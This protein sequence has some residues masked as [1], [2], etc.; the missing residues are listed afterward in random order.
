MF[1]D[2]GFAGTV[3]LGGVSQTTLINCYSMIAGALTPTFDM[4]GD[5]SAF[6]V[7]G[8]MGGI[9]VTNKTGMDGVS[10][11]LTS[12]QVIIDS[13]VVSGDIYVR[14][15]GRLTDNSTGTTYVDAEG[16][17]SGTR[18]IKTVGYVTV[19]SG[20]KSGTNYPIGTEGHPV[21]NMTD[22]IFI[23]NREGIYNIHIQDNVTTST[24][25]D[26]TDF[27]IHGANI[28][29][30]KISLAAGTITTKTKFLDI[31]LSGAFLGVDNELERCIINNVTNFTGI[32]NDCFLR[33]Y[34]S[35]AGNIA[36][37][38]CTVSYDAINHEAIFDF[39]GEVYGLNC[40]NWAEGKVTIKNM[41]TGGYAHIAGTG[42]K[43]YVDSSVTGGDAT[44]AGSIWGINNGTPDNF[45]AVTNAQAVQDI[46]VDDFDGI[47]ATVDVDAI[48]LA[49]ETQL[50]DEFNSLPTAAETA[51]A[52]DAIIAPKIPSTAA[53]SQA[54]WQAE[55]H[56]GLVPNSFG[57]LLHNTSYG[58][59]KVHVDTE[60]LINGD[61]SQA[62]P[63]NNIID[64]KEF[65]ETNGYRMLVIYAD[66]IVSGNMKNFIFDGVGAPTIE[67]AAGTILTR[68][69]FRHLQ[70]DAPDY[71]G[72]ITVQESVLL[73]GTSLNG[74]FEKCGL[75][76]DLVC[77]SNSNVLVAGCFSLIAGLN[78]PS[79]SMNSGSVA[80]V[81]LR[82]YSGGMTITDCDHVDDVI[83]VEVSQGSLTFDNTNVA[84]TMVAR[85]IGKFVNETAGASVVNEMINIDN[86]AGGIWNYG[87]TTPDVGSYGEA[88]N[89]I[90]SASDNALAVD[91][92]LADNF[93]N[94]P[95]AAENAA[96]NWDEPIAN[97]KV[98]GTFGE[99]VQKKLLSLKMFIGLYKD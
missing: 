33:N 99:W 24:G 51:T 63:F 16:L 35:M 67:I 65:A 61:G 18:T 26:L 40:A 28:A 10:I 3:V 36:M 30:S 17:Q 94:I 57:E 82:N 68:S 88:V 77:A 42:G 58:T 66:V 14:G 22:A 48:A 78:R 34:I 90:P 5:G 27:E 39:Q 46:L 73:N 92:Q 15:N 56:T 7:R 52:T 62:Y 54:I 21:N 37:K 49:V 95:D 79:I 43:M 80:N 76:G 12:G 44:H 53:I 84:G 2:C 91:T 50:A 6:A 75:A 47:T 64:A 81:S 41:V 87:I 71:V 20:G 9:K 70:L 13:T 98:A 29:S 85:G 11:D 38:N 89:D 83:T 8:Y 69:E 96:A 23:A 59:Y 32:I 25:D 45:T 1:Y 86:V 31:Y 4:S 60:L 72:N 93:A 97:H 55:G 19:T 74:F